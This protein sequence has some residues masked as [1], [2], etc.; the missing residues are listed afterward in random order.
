M[1][2]IKHPKVSEGVRALPAWSPPRT[3][4]AIFFGLL[5][6]TSLMLVAAF[7]QAVDRWTWATWAVLPMIAMNALW[8]SGGAA[9]ALLGLMTP[10][11]RATPAPAGWKPRQ[12]TANLITLC[13]EDPGPIADYLTSLSQAFKRVGLAQSTTIFALSDTCAGPESGLEEAALDPLRRSG[14]IL[15]RRRTRRTGKKP[16]NICD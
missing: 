13:G 9:T 4:L 12:K 8:V 2:A 16:G 7:V 5:V 1:T 11:D 3:P 14:T 10:K 6:L 15:Y